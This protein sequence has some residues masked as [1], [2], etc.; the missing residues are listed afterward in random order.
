[1]KPAIALYRA[2]FKPSER[3]EKPYAMLGFNAFAAD[4][5]EEAHFLA[6]SMQQ[7]FVNL[8][9]GRP[10]PLPRPMKDYVSRIGPHERALI[11]Q[12]LPY[13]AI[14]SPATV[15]E[16][17]Q[18]FIADT[19]ADEVMITSQI[20]DHAARLRSFEIVAEA[21]DLQPA[22]ASTPASFR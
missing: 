15:A 11:D 8:R 20:F 14:G 3:L 12:V 21:L 9:S 7:A 13:S 5:G 2:T 6:S 1:M 18:R 4:T 10:T 22:A 16:Q 17:L 19:N